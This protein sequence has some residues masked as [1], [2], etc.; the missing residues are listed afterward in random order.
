MENLRVTNIKI[1]IVRLDSDSD[2]GSE[3]DS[4]SVCMSDPSA[5]A[6]NDHTDH[7]D[8]AN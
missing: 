4:D 1:Q 3:S 7:A 6:A 8:R 5:A 2:S